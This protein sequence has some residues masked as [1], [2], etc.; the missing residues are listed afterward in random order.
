MIRNPNRGKYA[1]LAG[2]KVG[3]LTM[4]PAIEVWTQISSEFIVTSSP[5][6]PSGFSPL[7]LYFIS[8][9]FGEMRFLNIDSGSDYLENNPPG[10]LAVDDWAP[11]NDMPLSSIWGF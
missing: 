6:H 8:P 3:P 2:H 1:M 7:A 4:E 11:S 10:T 9:L 5:P